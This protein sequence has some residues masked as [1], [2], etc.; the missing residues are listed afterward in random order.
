MGLVGRVGRRGFESDSLTMLR[1]LYGER[2]AVVSVPAALH[3][4]EGV[5]ENRRR[6]EATSRLGLSSQEVM[7]FESTMVIVYNLHCYANYHRNR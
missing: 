2:G 4:V 7:L 6:T 5:K 3:G 1:P